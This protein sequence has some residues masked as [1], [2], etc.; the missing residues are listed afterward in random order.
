MAAEYDC[1]QAA[2][3]MTEEALASILSMEPFF[4][5]DPGVS[6][7]DFYPAV[8]DQFTYQGQIWGL[9][10]SAT[11][12]VVNY[13]KDLFD[14]AGLDYPAPDWTTSDFLQAAV[15]TTDRAQE[16][17]GYV[18]SQQG[19]NDL[20]TL[21]DRLGVDLFDDS[22]DPPTLVLDSPEAAQVMRWYTGLTTEYKVTPDLEEM[23]GGGPG[24]GRGGARQTL[25]NQGQVAMWT[26][27]GMP[28][29]SGQP[30]INSGVV[31]LPTGS[32]S[33]Q[34]SGFQSVDG[35]FISAQ[36]QA[37]QACWE[38]ITFLTTQPNAA[39]GLPAR[40]DVAESTEYRQ[41]VGEERA[42]ALL[43]SV[44]VGNRASFFQR[45]SDEGNWLMFASNWVSSAYS[46]I[47]DGEMTVEE[48]LADAQTKV[49]DYRTCVIANDAFGDMQA[50]RSCAQEVGG[51]AGGPP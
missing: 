5:A 51:M 9:P 35:Y 11:A 46:S 44:S 31:P 23:S 24:A 50:L 2:P 13:N 47:I 37:R 19:V 40:Q 6:K 4:S 21:M 42:D 12:N 8:L 7:E 29:G 33:A 27:G 45:M 18:P 22:E 36:T 20:I 26:D 39:S 34:G 25:I 38:W 32:N 48:A 30:D 14:A 28:G 17:Y 1:F 3:S 43:A 41:Q 15:A 16:Q 10:G 49:D